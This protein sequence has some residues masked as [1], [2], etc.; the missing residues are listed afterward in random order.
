MESVSGL[1]FAN[2][3]YA[4]TAITVIVLERASRSGYR[5]RPMQMRASYPP[6]TKRATLVHELGH[7]LQ[8]NL[9]RRGEQEHGWLFL[10]LYDVWTQLYGRSF[11]DAEVDVEKRRG[12]PYPAAW[13]SA[14][15][16]TAEERTVRWRTIR[17]ERLAQWCGD[18]IQGIPVSA[19]P[20][21]DDAGDANRVRP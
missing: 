8:S 12:G 3:I 9:F 15:V 11:A 10:W 6:S 2:P 13:D 18:N 4:D 7:R 16:L 14:M 1:R 21:C 17:D 19:L 5:D 20:W